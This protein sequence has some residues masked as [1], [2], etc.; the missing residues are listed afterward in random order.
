MSQIYLTGRRPETWMSFQ[1]EAEVIGK[2]D[3]LRWKGAALE[4][5]ERKYWLK[6]NLEGTTVQTL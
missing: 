4:R 6:P 2:V 3:R 1:S 5:R